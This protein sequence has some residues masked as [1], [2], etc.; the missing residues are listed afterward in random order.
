MSV[1]VSGLIYPRSVLAVNNLD[2]VLAK[3]QSDWIGGDGRRRRK[4]NYWEP[5][6]YEPDQISIAV[7]ILR[8][9]NYNIVGAVGLQA[10][11]IFELK[12]LRNYI[13][14]RGRD[15]R[16]ELENMLSSPSLRTISAAQYRWRQP[17]DIL[18]SV[19]DPIADPDF[20]VFDEWL[21]RFRKV[22]KEMII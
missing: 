10:N 12:P 15:T 19:I 16:K 18:S 4:P 21:K 22:A 1:N 9:R 2:E 7:T 5:F 17:V 20:T 13:V 11:P 6:W 8:T 3:L 14:H